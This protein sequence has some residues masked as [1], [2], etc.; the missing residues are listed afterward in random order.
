MTAGGE[1]EDEDDGRMHDDKVDITKKS[2]N[3]GVDDDEIQ[4]GGGHDDRDGDKDAKKNDD[5]GRQGD[6]R[7]G[8]CGQDMQRWTARSSQGGQGEGRDL[9]AGDVHHQHQQPGEEGRE[10]C[11]GDEVGWRGG[12]R[13]RTRDV[14][15]I[16]E[17]STGWSS[18]PG[19]RMR[20]PPL[21][22]P[23]T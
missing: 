17:M 21:S 6:D 3:M 8:D 1:I 2:E 23:S 12:K 7:G 20:D 19:L 22:P 4:D 16:E 18:L 9:G 10:V 14:C 13:K 5:R 15:N 11:K